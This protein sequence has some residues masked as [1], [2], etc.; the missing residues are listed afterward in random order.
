[1]YR[2]TIGYVPTELEVYK[3]LVLWATGHGDVSTGAVHAHCLPAT[4]IKYNVYNRS[5]CT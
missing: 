4:E 5:V 1:M 3:Q 2:T